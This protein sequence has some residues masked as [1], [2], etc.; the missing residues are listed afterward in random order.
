VVESRGREAVGERGQEMTHLCVYIYVTSGKLRACKYSAKPQDSARAARLRV[1]KYSAKPQR[2]AQR[3]EAINPAT[4]P[5]LYYACLR[6]HTYSTL[7][8]ELELVV[9][10]KALYMYTYYLLY[11]PRAQ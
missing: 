7:E 2:T 1:C 6:P 9:Y 8:L 10:P 3:G 4:R 5:Y 11:T